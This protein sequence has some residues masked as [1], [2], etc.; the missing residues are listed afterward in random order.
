[1]RVHDVYLI[2]AAEC[3]VVVDFLEA[4]QPRGWRKGVFHS[5]RGGLV[6]RGCAASARR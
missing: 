6:S 2:V 1:M 5:F 4:R 3:V